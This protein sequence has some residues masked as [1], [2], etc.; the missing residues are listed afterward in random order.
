LT[1]HSECELERAHAEVVGSS[2]LSL[3]AF[4]GARLERGSSERSRLWVLSLRG[5]HGHA[6]AASCSS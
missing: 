1:M 2:L 5:F 3:E 4:E 6:D